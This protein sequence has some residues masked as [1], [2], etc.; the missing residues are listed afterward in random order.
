V[1]SGV[2]L[3]PSSQFYQYFFSALPR[4]TKI[5]LTLVPQNAYISRVTKTVM[6]LVKIFFRERSWSRQGCVIKKIMQTL[7]RYVANSVILKIL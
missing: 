2:I 7:I 1:I 5:K 6:Y 4:K 3:R